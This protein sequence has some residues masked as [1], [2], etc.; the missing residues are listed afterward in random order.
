MEEEGGEG[1]KGEGERGID[2]EGYTH[3]YCSSIRLQRSQGVV[4]SS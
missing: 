4:R 1:E 3:Q 2:R